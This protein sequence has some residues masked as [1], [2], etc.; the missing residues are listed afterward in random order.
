MFNQQVRYHSILCVFVSTLL[1]VALSGCTPERIVISPKVDVNPPGTQHEITAKVTDSK[2]R[3]VAHSLVEW[4]LPR[5]E[6]AVGDIVEGGDDPKSTYPIPKKT[7]TYAKT[8]TNLDGEAKITI[9]SPLKGKT[10]IV[11][12]AK[13]IEDKDKHK[14][15]A[16]KY[17]SYINWNFPPDA[18]NLAGTPHRMEV[19]VHKPYSE[20]YPVRFKITKSALKALKKAK[21]PDSILRQLTDLHREAVETGTQDATTEARFLAMLSDSIGASQVTPYKPLILKHTE[22]IARDDELRNYRVE[23]EILSKFQITETSMVK[24][25]D[26][27]VPKDILRQLERV[28]SHR[29][30]IGKREF[31]A[32]I[33]ET[34]GKDQ[35]YEYQSVILRYSQMQIGPDAYF[36]NNGTDLVTTETDSKGFARVTL[37]QILP[38]EGQNQIRVRLKLPN[39]LPEGLDQLCCPKPSDV[40]AEGI[41]EKT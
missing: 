18:T 17:W 39:Q 38:K 5:S 21:L 20:Q 36:E 12:V 3:P 40:I 23:W 30:V 24:L 31:L 11:A 9:T 26:Q 22:Y 7:N 37:R 41:V 34:I 6:Q 8:R 2:G 29:E 35:L 13:G 16:V 28:V 1:M 27:G 25:R 14:A 10:S 32:F 4:S 15:F 19:R 33:A